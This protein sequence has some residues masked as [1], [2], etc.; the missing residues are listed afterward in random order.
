MQIETTIAE[1]IQ[2]LLRLRL[3]AYELGYCQA[4]IASDAERRETLEKFYSS[5]YAGDFRTNHNLNSRQKDN[6]QYATSERNR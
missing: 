1:T 4:L 2:S 5:R 6:S 3:S